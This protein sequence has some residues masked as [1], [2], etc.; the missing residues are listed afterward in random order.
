MRTTLAILALVA[1]CASGAPKPDPCRDAYVH[2]EGQGMFGGQ[3]YAGEMALAWGMAC[4]DLT[5]DD[6]ACIDK[7]T[8]M[9]D[10]DTCTHAGKVIR[11]RNDAFEHDRSAGNGEADERAVAKIADAVCRC[12][13]LAC[14][15]GVGE[16]QRA[17]LASLLDGPPP[18]EASA[19]ARRFGTCMMAMPPPT[20]A[21]P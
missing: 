6:L 5:K 1:G 17:P 8:T 4:D 3:E 19:G 16:H 15:V 7:A 21:R 13:D 14:L 10:L 20:P 9:S 12:K 2:V 11:A 18:A